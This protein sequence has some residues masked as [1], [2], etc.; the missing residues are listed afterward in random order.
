MPKY[1]RHSLRICRAKGRSEVRGCAL[2]KVLETQS[3][4]GIYSVPVTGGAA[5][6]V[7]PVH[8]LNFFRGLCRSGLHRLNLICPIGSRR[9]VS[10]ELRGVIKERRMD[11]LTG[12]DTP[13]NKLDNIEASNRLTS[14]LPLFFCSVLFLNADRFIVVHPIAC[15]V[16][17]LYIALIVSLVHF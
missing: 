10:R 17:L 2:T 9:T 4:R 16:F 5:W 13:L 3:G 15:H 1:M 14:P 8:S 6:L 7:S 12:L 11:R